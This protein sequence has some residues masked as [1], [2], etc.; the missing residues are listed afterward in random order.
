MISTIMIMI[1]LIFNIGNMDGNNNIKRLITIMVIK[2]VIISVIIVSNNNN[3][4]KNKDNSGNEQ[5]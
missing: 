4:I 2:I 1:N 5:R 3:Q